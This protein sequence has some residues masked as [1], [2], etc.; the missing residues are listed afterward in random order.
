MTRG[1]AARVPTKIHNPSPPSLPRTSRSG[2]GNGV[3][4]DRARTPQ[5]RFAAPAAGPLQ[6]RCPINAKYDRSELL[7]DRS[8]PNAASLPR[9]AR[10]HA[11]RRGA[12]GDRDPPQSLRSTPVRAAP[13]GQ[14]SHARAA[15][16]PPGRPHRRSTT[17]TPFV[18]GDGTVILPGRRRPHRARPA[19][20]GVRLRRVRAGRPTARSVRATGRIEIRHLVTDAVATRSRCA[21]P[22]PAPWPSRPAA[23]RSSSPAATARRCGTSSPPTKPASAGDDVHALQFSPDGRI[24]ATAPRRRRGEAL[25]RDRLE[26]SPRRSART[27]AASPARSPSASDGRTIAIGGRRRRRVGPARSQGAH[28]APPRRGAAPPPRS[29]P[30]ASSSPPPTPGGVVLWEP[31]FWQR[32][33]TLAGGQPATHVAYWPAAAACSPSRR[34]TARPALRPEH[35]RDGRPR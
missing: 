13:A 30:T 35:P 23:R 28:D 11:D 32:Q 4:G 22:I 9:A 29:A 26:R 34:P 7:R 6:R 25:G 15:H 18:P 12:A 10:P 19:A 2:G 33:A 14:P 21:S 24:L 20:A 5:S 1:S 16:R 31:V 27:S 8:E 3:L 17:A